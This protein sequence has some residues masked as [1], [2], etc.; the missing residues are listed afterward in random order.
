LLS[1]L[2]TSSFQR[3]RPLLS[4]HS[5]PTRRSSDLI[6]DWYRLGING[7]SGPYRLSYSSFA[8]G[9]PNRIRFADVGQAGDFLS[10]W[11]SSANTDQHY[12]GYAQDR[13]AVNNRLTI[14]AG[15][16]IDYQ[17]V[18]ITDTTKKPV[19]TDVTTSLQAGDGGR[20]FRVST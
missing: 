8:A 16:R 1:S 18:G 12:S 4:L 13:W 6:Y 3:S 10:G 14:S 20:I 5:F 9:V 7:T 2:Y 15:V 17:D 19:I 11:G